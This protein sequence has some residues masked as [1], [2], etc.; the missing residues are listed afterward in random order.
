MA[1][2]IIARKP[3]FTHQFK[4][5]DLLTVPYLSFDLR[6]HNSNLRLSLSCQTLRYQNYTSCCVFKIVTPEIHDPLVSIM[7]MLDSKPVFL[8]RIRSAGLSEDAQDRIVRGGVDT[9]AKLAFL[10]TVSPASGDDSNLFTELSQLMGYDEHAPMDSVTKSILRRIWFE[11]HATAIAEVKN[12]VERSDD[13]APRK[14][15]LPEREERRQKQQLKLSGVKVEGVHE[16]SYSLIDMIHTMREDEQVRYISPEQCT[17]REAELGGTKKEMFLQAEAG[18]RLK[19]VNREV[20]LEADI[21]T[22]YKLRLCLQRRSLALDQMDLMSYQFCEDYHEHLFDLMQQ[23]VPPGYA[24][25]SVNQILNADKMIWT[26]MSSHCRTGISRRPDGSLPMEVQLTAALKSPII[27]S[28]LQPLPKLGGNKPDQGGKGGKGYERRQEYLP[29]PPKGTKGKK[30]SK[31]TGKGKYKGTGQPESVIGTMSTT[32]KGQRICYG[33]N[34]SGCSK[35]AKNGGCPRGQ[36]VC[37]G[38]E[39]P[40]HGYSAC[41]KRS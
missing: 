16:P 26:Y 28:A 40:D 38:C 11:S 34:L 12:K 41:P 30:G 36:H 33:F 9:L 4:L 7:T 14:L 18:G 10:A 5:C 39:S 6:L 2:I 8:A 3:I 37:C 15:P 25:L 20:A 13:A 35:H 27:S 29:Y 1:L 32:S 31:G 19:Q 22:V 24:P 23:V 21:S 17:H